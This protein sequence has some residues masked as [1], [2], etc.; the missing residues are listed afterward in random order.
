[1]SREREYLI[2]RAKVLAIVALVL[3]AGFVTFMSVQPNEKLMAASGLVMG[4]GTVTGIVLG[5]RTAT[6]LGWSMFWTAAVGVGCF[7][8]PVA[9]FTL[10]AVAGRCVI[11]ARD[12][13]AHRSGRVRAKQ[14]HWADP[15][16]G[17]D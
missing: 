15:R 10:A 14:A 3:A 1:V 8:Y 11:L 5:V 7:L 6:Q 13:P 9:P 12:I 2:G 17:P 4:V 16:T